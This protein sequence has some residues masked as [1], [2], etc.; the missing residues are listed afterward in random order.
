M[1]EYCGYNGRSTTRSG[2]KSA[3]A[4]AASAANGCQ[5]R[6]AMKHRTAPASASAISR[7]SAW[8]AVFGSSGEPPPIMS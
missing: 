1:V 8:A 3:T 5:Y 6:I 7:A 4:L 2:A